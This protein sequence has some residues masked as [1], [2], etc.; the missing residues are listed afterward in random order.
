[1]NVRQAARIRALIVGTMPDQLAMPFYLW[2][3]ESVASLI[4]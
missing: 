4:E 1:L 3:R 2:T